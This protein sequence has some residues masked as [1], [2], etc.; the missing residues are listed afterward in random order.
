[1]L[2]NSVAGPVLKKLMIREF[3]DGP[4]VRS[5]HFHCWGPGL[6]PGWGTKI[7]QATWRS[8]KNKKKFT[9]KQERSAN[10]Y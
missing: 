7:P 4:K 5:W 10:I 8:H 9:V 2:R 1:M 6:N 3:P